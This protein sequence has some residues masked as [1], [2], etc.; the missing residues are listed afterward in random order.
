ML[1]LRTF[2]PLL[3]LAAVAACHPEAAAAPGRGLV[4]LPDD[5]P[6]PRG[7]SARDPR[8]NFHD[9]GRVGDGDTVTR[10]FRMENTDPRPVAI[11]RVTPGCGCTVPALRAVLADGTV[12][13]GE[14]A[15]SKAPKLL[16]IPPGAVF[17]LELA[18]HTR[19]MTTKNQ[20]KLLTVGLVTDSP[21]GYFLTLELHLLVEKPFAVVPGALALGQVPENGGKQGKVEIVRAGPF[22]HALG[23]LIEVPA[24]VEAQLTSEERNFSTVW[25]LRAML[26]PPLERGTR[27]HTLRISTTDEFGEPGRALEVPLT[28]QV[29]ADLASDPTRCVLR[30]AP[31]EESEGTIELYSL[32]PGHRLKVVGIDVPPENSAWLSAEAAA[33]APDDDGASARWLLTLRSRPPYP[34]GKALSGKVRVRLDDPQHPSHELEYV[35]HVR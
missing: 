5:S 13:A 18:I 34:A 26:T 20:D 16:E 25:T 27:Q 31:E 1:S 4:I 3:L 28:A 24:G 6:L 22:A 12:V 15:S 2:A 19:D 29:V 30:S 10:I 9:F 21:N 7:V 32:L 33:L 17:E 35:V 14:P 23:E 8:L 11:T